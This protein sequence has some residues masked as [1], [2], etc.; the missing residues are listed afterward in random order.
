[1]LV[2]KGFEVNLSLVN[3]IKYSIHI[4]EIIW[5]SFQWI[6]YLV[7]TSTNRTI[8]FRL[9]TKYMM[10]F[11]W[12]YEYIRRKEKKRKRLGEKPQLFILILLLRTA[13]HLFLNYFLT[14][15][16][17]FLLIFAFLVCSSFTFL[18]P[19][20]FYMLYVNNLLLVILICIY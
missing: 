20:Q 11:I 8:T 1:M 7:V 5:H 18:N 10:Y 12:C 9:F 19:S 15:S 6:N 3:T 17:L 2:I 4:S 14:V 13:L 16:K